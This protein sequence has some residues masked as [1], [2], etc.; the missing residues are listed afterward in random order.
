MGLKLFLNKIVKVDNIE[1]YTLRTLLKLREEY[2]RFVEKTGGID[3]DFPT[4]NFGDGEGKKTEKLIKKGQK[5]GKIEDR[6][7]ENG[8]MKLTKDG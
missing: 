1:N 4:L 5:A 3:P 8:T 7:D 6:L 2:D